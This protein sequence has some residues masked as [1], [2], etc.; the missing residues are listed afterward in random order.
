MFAGREGSDAAVLPVE[1]ARG[2]FGPDLM[3]RILERWSILIHDC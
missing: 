3:S 1:A 2:R